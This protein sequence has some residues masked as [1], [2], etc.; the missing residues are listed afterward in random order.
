MSLRGKFE[1][2]MAQG[3]E[4]EIRSVGEESGIVNAKTAPILPVIAKLENTE[5]FI[6]GAFLLGQD[7]HGE[8]DLMLTEPDLQDP[9]LPNK[10]IQAWMNS[11][12]IMEGLKDCDSPAELLLDFNRAVIATAKEFSDAEVM[13]W[14]P[15]FEEVLNYRRSN[16]R[17]SLR[18]VAAV[19][20]IRELLKQALQNMM[21]EFAHHLNNFDMKAADLDVQ[22]FLDEDTEFSSDFQGEW[23]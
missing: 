10:E 12:M 6:V 4:E 1:E 8:A 5:P 2:M 17:R 14:A 16:N 7:E 11:V 21:S 23:A 18:Q 9:E 22:S 15:I 20:N 13:G 3:L 19:G